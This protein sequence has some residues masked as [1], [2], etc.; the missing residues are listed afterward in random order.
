MFSSELPRTA[1]V[2]AHECVSVGRGNL[3]HRRRF[4]A[5]T[6]E[7]EGDI[8]LLCLPLG[9]GAYIITNLCALLLKNKS[10]FSS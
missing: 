1:R 2:R 6:D 7:E 4:Y 3:F 5:R 10:K 9:C 8:F